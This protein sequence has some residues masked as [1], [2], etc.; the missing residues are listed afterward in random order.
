MELA[1]KKR[2]AVVYAIWKRVLRALAGHESNSSAVTEEDRPDLYVTQ[3][4]LRDQEFGIPPHRSGGCC[5]WQPHI[6][7]TRNLKREQ[8]KRH[9]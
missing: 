7:S 9:E 8:E 4:E 6:C 3:S 2:M 5:D 1:I